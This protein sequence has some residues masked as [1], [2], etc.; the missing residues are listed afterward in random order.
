MSTPKNVPATVLSGSPALTPAPAP[1]P[2]PVPSAAE[3][4]VA[5]IFD[6]D[7]ATTAVRRDHPVEALEVL[8]A[9]EGQWEQVAR[10]NP[11][12]PIPEET[13]DRGDVPPSMWEGEYQ[14][15]AI[16]GGAWH[17]PVSVF[18]GFATIV[19]YQCA[20][21]S[22]LVA[23]PVVP[24]LAHV[25]FDAGAR[26]YRTWSTMSVQQKKLVLRDAFRDALVAITVA[27]LLHR[28]GQTCREAPSEFHDVWRG[29]GVAMVDALASLLGDDAAAHRG[30]AGLGA[31]G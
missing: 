21:E 15:I 24:V 23:L 22:I 18:P 31:Y 3:A 7:F 28:M 13:F 6:V 14:A 26:R 1:A 8:L 29:R 16:A 10:L 17:P 2:A 30:M 9:S 25:D 27:D 4:R 19:A 20:E 12:H 11:A 5:D